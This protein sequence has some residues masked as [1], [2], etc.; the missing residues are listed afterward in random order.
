MKHDRSQ[1]LAT[2]PAELKAALDERA[3][4][5]ITDAQGK[6]TYLTTSSGRFPNTNEELPG[7]DHRIINSGHHPRQP[8]AGGAPN[9]SP[10][11]LK[12]AN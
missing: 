1:C 12:S 11:F 3:I 10:E 4:V 5:A 6:I 9:D 2:E 8:Y 7:Q